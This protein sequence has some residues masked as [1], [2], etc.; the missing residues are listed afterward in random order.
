[1]HS[2][3]VVNRMMEFLQ[4]DS[5]A[6]KGDKSLDFADRIK[7]SLHTIRLGNLPSL[8]VNNP[9]LSK[10]FFIS[11]LGLQYHDKVGRVYKISESSN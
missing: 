9:I 7:G 4:S 5:R 2:E 10:L 6:E 3:Y 8:A 1:M 11:L